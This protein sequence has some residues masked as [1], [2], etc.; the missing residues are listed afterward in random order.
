[1]CEHFTLEKILALKETIKPLFSK[2]EFVRRM[3]LLDKTLGSQ[4]YF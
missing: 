3:V 4:F 1:M 2:A